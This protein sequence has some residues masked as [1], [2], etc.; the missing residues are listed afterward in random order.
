MEGRGALRCGF[1]RFRV[2]ERVAA[3]LLESSGSD[4][5]FAAYVFRDLLT[6]PWVV[7]PG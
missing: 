5:V 3:Y 4:G 2:F 6:F 7:L 1:S